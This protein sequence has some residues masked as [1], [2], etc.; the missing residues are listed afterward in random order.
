[1]SEIHDRSASASSS[2]GSRRSP[3]HDLRARLLACVTP[4]D[5]QEVMAVLVSQAKQGNM[6][7][8]RLFFAYV[9]GKPGNKD[10]RASAADTAE[11]PGANI[12][13]APVAVAPEEP[14]TAGVTGP[15]PPAGTVPSASGTCSTPAPIPSK[16]LESPQGWA[17]RHVDAM[18]GLLDPANSAQP[19]G[20]DGVPRRSTAIRYADPWRARSGSALNS[21]PTPARPHSAGPNRWADADRTS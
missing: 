8:I 17:D 19:L 12:A 6:S 7:A 9:I 15:V 21:V 11:A 4:E 10:D 18:I 3:M 13:N 1:M 16:P 14:A 2:V 20:R 5:A